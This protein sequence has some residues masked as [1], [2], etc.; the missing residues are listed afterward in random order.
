MENEVSFDYSKKYTLDELIGM[1]NQ[2]PQIIADIFCDRDHF[3]EYG[4][5][6]VELGMEAINSGY[7]PSFSDV[8]KAPRLYNL[9]TF[10][11]DLI[12]KD[13]SNFKYVGNNISYPPT[14]ANYMELALYAVRNGYNP[15]IEDVINNPNLGKSGLIME[16]LVDENPSNFKYIGHNTSMISEFNK[17]AYQAVKKGYKPQIEDL[18]NNKNLGRF[19]DICNCFNILDI[20]KYVSNEEIIESLNNDVINK[21][22]YQDYLDNKYL[23]LNKKIILKFIKDYPSIILNSEYIDEE[24]INIALNNGL[25]VDSNIIHDS[26]NI[27]FLLRNSRIIKQ[28]IDDDI[29]IIGELENLDDETA[30]ETIS[31]SFKKGYRGE[32]LY[33]ILDFELDLFKQLE[34]MNQE[35]IKYVLNWDYEFKYVNVEVFK[36]LVD[37]NYV[38]SKEVLTRCINNLT[39]FDKH[40][41]SYYIN[42]N[43]NLDIEFLLEHSLDILKPNIIIELINNGI[44]INNIINICNNIG[45]ELREEE[46]IEI[47]KHGFVIPK[48]KLT[49]NILTSF[50]CMYLLCLKDPDYINYCKDIPT[51][52]K[53]NIMFKNYIPSELELLQYKI[54]KEPLIMRTIALTSPKFIKYINNHEAIKEVIDKH[55]NITIKG[56]EGKYFILDVGEDIKL[57]FKFI[58]YSF[59]K[60][61]L[62]NLLNRSNSKENILKLVG[63]TD[64]TSIKNI[65]DISMYDHIFK[66]IMLFSK[67]I[68]IDREKITVEINS[69]EFEFNISN[70]EHYLNE[71]IYLK[72][73]KSINKKIP[74]VYASLHFNI[75][76]RIEIINNYD[77]YINFINKCGIEEDTLIQYGLG[78]SNEWLSILFKIIDNNKEEN[79]IKIF[80]FIKKTYLKKDNGIEL[81][82]DT[83][84]NYD[85]YN[86]L[87]DSLINNNIVLDE[88]TKKQLS[89]LLDTHGL[90]DE[91]EK[92]K[93]YKDLRNFDHLYKYKCIYLLSSS[94]NKK[95]ALCKIL[96]NNTPEYLSNLLEIY[97]D[98]AEFKKLRF[99]TNNKKLKEIID[100][101]MFYVS[102]IDDIV[103]MDD[104]R[105]EE[106]SN[107]IIN[108]F[109]NV[110][111]IKQAFNNYEEIMRKF[112]EK[113]ANLSVT[114]IDKD[115]DL[116]NKEYCLLVHVKSAN[117]TVE[118]IVHGISSLQHNFISLSAISW[119][120]QI[121]Y[122]GMKE[123]IIIFGYDKIP[124]GSFIQSSTSNMNTNTRL[125]QNDLTMSNRKQRGILEISN[126]SSGNGE[127]LCL[128]KGLKPC[129]IIIP[130]REPTEKELEISKRFGLKL[131][132]TQSVFNSIDSPEKIELKEEKIDISSLEKLKSLK[133]ELFKTSN[134]GRRV[135]LFTD[136]H[137]LYEPLLAVLE[138]IRKKGITEIYSLGDN[139]GA[140]PNPKEVL[141]LLDEYNVKSIMGNHEL[142]LTTGVEGYEQHLH[143]N[144][145]EAELNSN[146]TKNQLNES[147]INKI[148]LYPKV[149]ELLLGGKKVALCHYTKDY[150][151]NLEEINRETYDY[152]YQGHIH[153]EKDEDKIKTLSGLSIGSNDRGE[154]TYYILTEKE[155][156]FDI[157]KV[158]VLYDALNSNYSIIK[159]SLNNHDKNKIKTWIKEEKSK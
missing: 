117:E 87:F 119:R 44:D 121:F 159:S 63:E 102:F 34:Q 5:Y 103:N 106:L 74:E 156:G 48:D 79:Y 114:H 113:E 122:G 21:I 4:D 53:L 69:K 118:E 13:P 91:K 75:L 95:E 115:I 15:T 90:F 134:P 99:N 82:I 139:I 30:V 9:L 127:I 60:E 3:F 68:S 112:Y 31:Y 72:I 55:P 14:K 144:T 93:D 152:I 88:N 140:G 155:E 51:K 35:V 81:L 108:N 101:V 39:Y 27:D 29:E 85:E 137:A 145:M 46:N 158:I 2:N 61:T 64:P 149:I 25:E 148:K 143:G 109:D 26:I 45:Y 131:V 97:G 136:A 100:V 24:L 40:I 57:P 59:S 11:K 1:I 70:I 17:L 98:T 105:I 146:W 6:S 41:L 49:H 92:P 110:L 147:D 83:I 12:Y 89:L 7:K 116:S 66:T 42:K 38:F 107:N 80:D 133:E 65:T 130:N 124:T 120:N 62:Y 47:I 142:Y 22:I 94:K 73:Q 84:S 52:I 28:L 37:K 77:K 23:S 32:I 150:N 138:D 123:D 129:S 67:I 56:I 86:E 33:E 153:F 43:K 18:K 58:M 96:F 20:I 126:C 78:K 104:N 76:D 54:E 135:A 10:M 8:K 154:A 151:T 132:K 16:I 111:K 19:K 141:E 125:I 157:E 36:Y 71:E 128:R 50:D